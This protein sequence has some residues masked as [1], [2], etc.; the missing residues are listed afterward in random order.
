[1]PAAEELDD[2]ALLAE[3]GLDAGPADDITQLRNVRSNAER[4]AADDIASAK[5]CEDF[6]TF[7]R[8]FDR[9]QV[10]LEVGVRTTRLFVR[11]L[12]M[13]NTEILGGDFFV[14]GG[15]IEYV[16]EVE[17]P[18]EAPDGES[19]ARLRVIYSNGT[20]SDLLLRPLQRALYKDEG[21][22]RVSERAPVPCLPA[23]IQDW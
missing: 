10:D 5:R 15:Q 6:A 22:R 11:D 12:G 21:G 18:I 17:D 3:F 4:A 14:V 19:D 20:E 2:D 9:V 8:L 13:S 7:R 16:A 23:P 1:M